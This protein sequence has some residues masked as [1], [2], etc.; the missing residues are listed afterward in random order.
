MI[1]KHI[2]KNLEWLH[3]VLILSMLA[4]VIYMADWQMDPEQIYRMYF[5]GYLLIVPVIG[6]MKAE[7]ECKNFIQYLA[8]V[9]CMCFVIKISAQNLSLL[10]LNE[11][12][13]LVYTGYSSPSRTQT[14]SCLPVRFCPLPEA[15]GSSPDVFI[16]FHVLNLYPYGTST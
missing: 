9:L 15:S 2:K 13:A 11:R 4:P 14:T 1:R 5:A 3:V 10:I 12:A 7:K 16:T 8:I 6:L